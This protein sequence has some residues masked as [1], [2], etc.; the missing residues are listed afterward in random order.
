MFSLVL[1]L[2]IYYRTKLLYKIGSKEK[3]KSLQNHELI[4]TPILIIFIIATILYIFYKKNSWCIKNKEWFWWL[5]KKDWITVEHHSTM[6]LS[7]GQWL[8]NYRIF[9]LCIRTI[10]PAHHMSMK[11]VKKIVQCLDTDWSICERKSFY[12]FFN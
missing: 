5:L 4:S 6:N 8:I 3:K 10:S 1:R 11:C 7:S 9:F 12:Y 2:F